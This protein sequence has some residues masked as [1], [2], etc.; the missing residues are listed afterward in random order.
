M[1]HAEIIK[2][3]VVIVKPDPRLRRA[4]IAAQQFLGKLGKATPGVRTLIRHD[5]TLHWLHRQIRE[6]AVREK[7]R[8]KAVYIALNEKLLSGVKEFSPVIKANAKAFLPIKQLEDG[9]R[10]ALSTVAKEKIHSEWKKKTKRQVQ[11]YGE[12][13]QHRPTHG[14]RR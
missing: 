12:P 14:K 13:W 5:Q 7:Y 2:N 6:F 4:V 8:G 3:G 1:P 10:S 9:I 11:T